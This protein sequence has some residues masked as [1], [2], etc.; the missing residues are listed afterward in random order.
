MNDLVERARA[1]ATKAHASIDQR[2]KYTNEPYVGHPIAVARIVSTVPHDPEMLAAA[3]LH[4]V[5]EDTPVTIE[6]IRTEFGDRVADM[7]S[8]LT[9]VSQPGDGNRAVRKALDR[10][11]TAQAS[12]EAQT[13]KLADLIDNTKSITRHD[14][15]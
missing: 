7:V 5:V 9:D 3:L 6:E 8:D 10:E 15:N 14:P 12:P 2:R 4:D 13:I 11:H 1:F